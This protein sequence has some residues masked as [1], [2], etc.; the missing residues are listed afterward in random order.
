MI[1]IEGFI[2]KKIYENG[3]FKIYSFIPKDEYKEKVILHPTYGNMSISG[4]MPDLMKETLYKVDL[5]YSKKG[6]YDNYEVKRIHNDNKRKIDSETTSKFI[7]SICTKRQGDELLKHY[8]DIANM[9]IKN[10]PIN[11]NVLY[12]IKEKTFNKIKIKVI[13]NFKLIDLVDE[14]RD[15]GM[16]FTMIKNLYN[17][18]SSVKIIKKKMEE[19]PYE[20]LCKVNRVG[21]KIADGFVMK[22]YPEKKNSYMRAKA[23][24]N[25]VLNENE[26]NG[27][28]WIFITELYKKIKELANEASIHFYDILKE[29]DIYYNDTTKR[30]AKYETYMCEKEV[31]N[32][33]LKFNSKSTLLDIDYRKYNEIDGCPITEEQME[34]LKNV[35]RNNLNLLVG[36]AGT[37]KSFSTKALLNMLNDNLIT[38]TLMSPTGKAAKV[39]SENSGYP[40]TTIHRGLK[41][42]PSEGF[43]FNMNN[44]LPQDVII[45]DEFS[46][47]D[48]FLLR[49]LLRAIDDDSKIIFIGDPAQIPSVSMGNVAFDMLE[50]K[51]IPT[52]RLTKV[53]RYGEGGLSYVATK[54]RAGERYLKSNDKVQSY[55][56]KSDYVFINAPQESSLE[57]MERLYN[58][59][60]NN[61]VKIDDIMVLSAMNKGEYG[62]N[63]INNVIQSFVNPENKDK[64][65]ISSRRNNDI[66]IFREG[67]KVMQ[68]K[69]NYKALTPEENETDIYNGDTGII[70]NVKDDSIIVNY[71]D[72]NIEYSKN[73]LD[74][75]TLAYAM[76]LHKCQGS[77]F[78]YIIL[79]TPK[80]HTYMLDRNLLYVA[81]TRTKELIYH[82]GSMEVV[83]SSLRKSQ[84]FSRNTF[85]EDML[86]AG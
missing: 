58:K 18:Y 40:A 44:K 23:C 22:K 4:I 70:T 52:S 41:Y 38:Y 69:N 75:L 37:G 51:K 66:V 15:Y 63:K 48:I 67:D 79:I 54:I 3:D 21:F 86:I 12:G 11:L 43:Y 56:E 10:K 46:M 45:I 33:L 49:D 35:C 2:T 9:I 57:I 34:I 60:L 55:G 1:T 78:K 7:Y 62:V 26:T 20:C 74:Q 71:G 16:T 5:E 81:I 25:Y 61:G 36:Y 6:K 30:V 68:I 76:T 19:N 73:E 80:A 8:P 27:N 64:K 14:Y 83:N 82:I 47:I 17:A 53:F 50:S 72:K 24:V 84:N 32:L 42:K 85:L 39:L 65:E 28:T 31:C 13:E 59:L 29:D 77:G